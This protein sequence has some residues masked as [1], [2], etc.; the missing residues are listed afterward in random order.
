MKIWKLSGLC[1]LLFLTHTSFAQDL[2]PDA[3]IYN[4]FDAMRKHDGQSLQAQFTD[5]A[6]LQRALPD[7]SIKTSEI[8][9]FAKNITHASAYLDEHL[10]SVDIRQ[11]GN[12]ASVWTPYAFYRDEAL[13]HCGVNSFQVVKT[14]NG[15]KIQH[16]IDN[17][18][19][20]NCLEFINQHKSSK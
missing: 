13:S 2:S 20:G 9:A 6:I 10:L 11:N 3:P 19:Q 4:V 7:G 17:T 18:Y 15:W 8:D 16:L 1:V 12:L 5:T 14:V